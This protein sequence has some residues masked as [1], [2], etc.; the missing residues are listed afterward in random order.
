MVLEHAVD[1]DAVH[2]LRRIASAALVAASSITP[3]ES[4]ADDCLKYEP[5]TVSISGVVRRQ[6]FPGPPNYEDV[7][8]GDRPE[9]YGSSI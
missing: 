5:V 8:A 1:G 9:V 3:L 4:N 7:N 6:E 2:M